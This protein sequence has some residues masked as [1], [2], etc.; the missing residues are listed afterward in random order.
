MAECPVWMMYV[1]TVEEC[2]GGEPTD[3]FYFFMAL[4]NVKINETS[5]VINPGDEAVVKFVIND[6]NEYGEMVGEFLW[7][8]TT[9]P[10]GVPD[11]LSDPGENIAVLENSFYTEGESFIWDYAGTIEVSVTYLGIEYGPLSVTYVNS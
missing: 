2:T 7:N 6:A 10:S 4:N 5:W 1:D 9:N 11:F 8:Y 3:D